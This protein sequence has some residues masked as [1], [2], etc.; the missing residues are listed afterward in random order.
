MQLPFHRYPLWPSAG[1]ADCEVSA[2][3]PVPWESTSTT[4]SHQWLAWIHRLWQRRTRILMLT[5]QCQIVGK[6]CGRSLW[7]TN[8]QNCSYK[9]ALRIIHCTYK[10]F[11]EFQKRILVAT[12]LFGRGIDI[13]R[14][15]SPGD[16]RTLFWIKRQRKGCEGLKHESL[17]RWME[18]WKK[19]PNMKSPIAGA[20]IVNHDNKRFLQQH[21]GFC[22]LDRQ[23]GWPN[24]QVMTSQPN[25]Q[26][27]VI[28][29]VGQSIENRNESVKHRWSI[30]FEKTFHESLYDTVFIGWWGQYCHQVR[31]A[32]WKRLL[33]ASR[34]CTESLCMMF[35][36]ITTWSHVAMANPKME[37]K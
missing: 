11:K 3:S 5:F 23:Q 21:Y 10:Q 31:H 2:A 20:I 36:W 26:S 33:L 22:M 4:F 15:G 16:C 17:Q 13:E 35:G 8:C 25:L 19:E 7:E 27:K 9:P 14:A 24:R 34:I 32:R 37:L 29:V 18:I 12:D 1:R 30:S 6:S 28:L